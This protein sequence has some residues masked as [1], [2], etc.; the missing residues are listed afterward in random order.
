[1]ADQQQ[2]PQREE[3]QPRMNFMSMLL[4]FFLIRSVMNTFMGPKQ[5]ENPGTV[6]DNYNKTFQ[7][8]EQQ[9]PLSMDNPISAAMGLFKGMMPLKKGVKGMKYEPLLKDG[10]LCVVPVV[11]IEC[12]RFTCTDRTRM[13]TAAC[14]RTL[15]CTRE[16]T[17]PSPPRCRTTSSTSPF[18]SHSNSSTTGPTT[19]TFSSARPR[20]FPRRRRA[21][22]PPSV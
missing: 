18:L 1:M 22:S 17:P 7:T 10:D 6:I 13:R 19:R 14:P 12:S 5:P 20:L 9:A 21:A 2:Q 15:C 16:R 4:M 11:W 3:E 8:Q